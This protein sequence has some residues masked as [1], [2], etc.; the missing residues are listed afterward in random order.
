[1]EKRIDA[2]IKTGN[3][4]LAVELSDQLAQREVI[5]RCLCLCYI[6]VCYGHDVL[7]WHF[8]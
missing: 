4:S 8:T 6:A 1:M 2:A 5:I 7:L 3:V